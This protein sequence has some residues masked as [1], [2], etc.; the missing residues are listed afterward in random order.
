MAPK[1]APL[2]GFKWMLCYGLEVA[3][4]C[5]IFET[6]STALEWMAGGNEQTRGNKRGACN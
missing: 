1:D 3:S 5:S 2:L 4:A 6:L